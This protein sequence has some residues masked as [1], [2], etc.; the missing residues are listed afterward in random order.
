MHGY[1]NYLTYTVIIVMVSACKLSILFT[2]TFHTTEYVPPTCLIL[3]SLVHV[4]HQSYHQSLNQA[5]EPRFQ[6]Q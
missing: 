5:Y 1:L 4:G 3:D 2:D 6:L